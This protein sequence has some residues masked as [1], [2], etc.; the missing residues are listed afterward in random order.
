LNASCGAKYA[1]PSSHAWGG[2]VAKCDLRT[3]FLTICSNML[4]VY[5]S[6]AC[7]LQGCGPACYLL[8]TKRQKLVV[9]GTD[10]MLSTRTHACRIYLLPRIAGAYWC[11]CGQRVQGRWLSVASQDARRVCL[12]VRP[13]RV[14][15]LSLKRR[16]HQAG[17][18]LQG[19]TS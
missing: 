1:V 7:L 3:I 19:Q 8:P 15:H 14:A 17:R 2:K 12:D 5:D 18:C 10:N 13:R 16:C 4:G 11:G 6:T 9:M